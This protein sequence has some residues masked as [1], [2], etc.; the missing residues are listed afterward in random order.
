MAAA[1]ARRG[2][3]L[4]RVSPPSAARR[5]AAAS[6]VVQRTRVGRVARAERAVGRL[7]GRTES[8]LVGGDHHDHAPRLR[9]RAGAAAAR[10]GK[11]LAADARARD[12]EL[13]DLRFVRSRDPRRHGLDARDRF[14]ARRRVAAGCPA[15]FAR[16]LDK[17]GRAGLAPDR[18]RVT[19]RAD[20]WIA[21]AIAAVTLALGSC[22]AAPRESASPAPTATAAGAADTS[23]ALAGLSAPV[24]IVV[25]RWG[26]PHV[27]A[28][29]VADLYF[30]WGF[31]SA[32][33][34]LWQMLYNRQSADGQ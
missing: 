9:V 28:A 26:I 31:V 20:R 2:D 3:R 34:R 15:D 33:D 18:G 4:A 27:R 7:P 22:R 17:A 30:A 29:N 13:R 12:L 23:V 8:R 6:G 14:R 11:H 5:A 24:R 16:S 19:P 25:D 1:R 21:L 32:R 10:V